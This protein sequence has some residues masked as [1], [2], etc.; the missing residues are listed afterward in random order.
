MPVEFLGV[1]FPVEPGKTHGEL[2]S[3]DL[4]QAA[5]LARAHEDYGWDKVLVADDRGSADPAMI[6]AYVGSQTELLDIVVAHRPAA[7]HPLAAARTFATLDHLSGGRLELLI[8]DDDVSPQHPDVGGSTPTSEYLTLLKLAWTS[9]EPFSFAGRH[10]RVEGRAP[11]IRPAQSPRPS[12]TVRRT[13]G[14][15]SEAAAAAADTVELRGGGLLPTAAQLDG[16]RAGAGAAGRDSARFQ[17]AFRA[18]IGATARIA[19]ERAAGAAGTTLAGDARQGRTQLVGTPDTVATTL[20]AYYDL[21]VRVF[22]VQGLDTRTDAVDFGRHVIPL[23]RAEVSRREGRATGPAH[24][25][26]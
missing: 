8:D 16:I 1:A 12:I 17:V 22:S 7:G 5:R 26:A 2:S 11:G 15:P 13:G 21:G 25:V 14:T 3:L 18:V 10:Y 9:S 23:V 6:A 4:Y 20:L 24:V 19:E